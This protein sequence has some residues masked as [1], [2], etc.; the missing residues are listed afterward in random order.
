M[1]A[2][3]GMSAT[4]VGRSPLFSTLAHALISSSISTP[5]DYRTHLLYAYRTVIYH[6]H[7]WS[8]LMSWGALLIVAI[9]VIGGVIFNWLK[10]QRRRTPPVRV[11]SKNLL[12]SHEPTFTMDDA[13]E[14][15]A[16]SSYYVL[17][18]HDGTVLIEVVRA[19]GTTVQGYTS[20]AHVR[21]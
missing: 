8:S 17:S 13:I 7:G 18:H 20:T 2:C 6:V 1:A 21:I 14:V 9:I 10:N 5:G 15:Y 16:G 3:T 4:N 12:L 11:L 19:D